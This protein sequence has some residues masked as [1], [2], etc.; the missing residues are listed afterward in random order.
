MVLAQHSTPTT[1]VAATPHEPTTALRTTAVA[2]DP[3][4]YAQLLLSAWL[5]SSADEATSAQARRAQS[6]RPDFELPDQAAD[7][8]PQTEHRARRVTW[9][10]HHPCGQ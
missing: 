10:P 7:P 6:T 1:A 8:V 5:R 2:A 3:A 9:R 4:T